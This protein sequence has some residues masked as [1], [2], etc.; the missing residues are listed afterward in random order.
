MD[1]SDDLRGEDAIDV[2][3]EK[4]ENH[5]I[6]FKEEEATAI[7]R[8]ARRIGGVMS[9]QPNEP[10]TPHITRRQRWMSRVRSMTRTPQ[11]PTIFW[12]TTCSTAVA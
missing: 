7:F 8:L 1:L 9:R 12:P 4:N 3:V 10:T 2:L 6:T 5:V 11:C